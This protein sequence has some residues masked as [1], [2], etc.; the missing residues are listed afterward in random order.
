ML[1]GE[2]KG[3][4]GEASASLPDE[5]SAK[6]APHAIV[7]RG[8]RSRARPPLPP[9]FKELGALCRAGKLFAVQDWFKPHAY[10]EPERVNSKQWPMGIVIEKGFHSLVEV[11][12]QNGIPPDGRVLSTAIGNRSE[13]IVRLLLA[14]GA[15][16]DSVP[17][18]TVVHTG[19]PTLIRLFIEG[20]ADVESEVKASA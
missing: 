17:F 5:V 15:N 20:G 14:Y 3:T 19:S 4:S 6:S 18:S 8:S 7:G 9:D 16:F 1:G 2:Q 13:D 10:E 12:L 11:L